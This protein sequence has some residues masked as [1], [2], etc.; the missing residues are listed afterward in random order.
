MRL[1]LLLASLILS[2]ALPAA[3]AQEL[4]ATCHASS[5]Y[6]LTVKPASLMFDRPQPAPFHVQL[7][8]GSLRT[9]GA[10]V[11]L[12]AE[13]QDRLALF[14]REL[15]ALVPRLRAVA[16]AGVELAVRAVHAEAAGLSL[17]PATL[18]ELDRRLA[19]HATRLRERI[20]HSNSTHDWQGGT[21][22]QLADRIVGDLAP[23][24]AADLGQQA[25][26]AAMNGD[27]A[28]AARLRDEA[29]D[30]A[31]R[32][33]PRLQRRMQALRPQVLALCPSIRRLA[34]LQQGVRG[35]DGRPLDLLQVG[36]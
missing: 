12:R 18:A 23:L 35:A 4:A 29:A 36:P 24:V 13:D 3:H 19:T 17:A 1:R 5:S 9:D 11:R 20:A 22:Q 31:T 7:A 15:R 21:A 2:A 14:E 34:E 30:L 6:D 33:Q 28:E 32:L 10:A 16:E 25:L 8:G 27:L 26:G